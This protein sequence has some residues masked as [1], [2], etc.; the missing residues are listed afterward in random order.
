MTSFYKTTLSQKRECASTLDNNTQTEN[1]KKM[2]TADTRCAL[3]QEERTLTDNTQ[4][5]TARFRAVSVP[6]C[7]VPFQP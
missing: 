4:S 1:T 2:K 3:S 5:D 7:W 6:F